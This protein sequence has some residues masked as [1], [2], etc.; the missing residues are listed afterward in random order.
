MAK[1]KKNE[2]TLTAEDVD[3]EAEA[4]EN[5]KTIAA[6][7]LTGD[8]R[9]FMLDRLRHE[10]DKRPWNKRS[11]EEQRVTVAAVEAACSA[12]VTKAVEIIAASGRRTIKATLSKVLIKD[13]IS[14][15]IEVSRH[16]ER[17]HHLV[18][19]QGSTVLI[20]VADSADF[21]GERAPAEIMPDQG[22]LVA[23]AAVVH[24]T[25]DGKPEVPFH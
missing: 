14:A 3:A 7:V 23:S 24:S 2:P 25:A 5:A 19:A 6:K 10:Q 9:D 11:E 20:V 15:Q 22:D 12:M 1:P 17:R 13:G 18:D 16:D 21:E 8:M 4:A